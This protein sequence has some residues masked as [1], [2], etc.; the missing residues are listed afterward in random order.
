MRATS[1]I[2]HCFPAI[3]S[4]Q[5]RLRVGRVRAEMFWKVMRWKNRRRHEGFLESRLNGGWVQ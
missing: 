4:F 2:V 1:S 5:V 3:I